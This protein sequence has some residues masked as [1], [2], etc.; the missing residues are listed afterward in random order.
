MKLHRIAILFGIVTVVGLGLASMGIRLTGA[1]TQAVPSSLSLL[2]Q[3]S[4][5][6]DDGEQGSIN[7]KEATSI[8]CTNMSTEN[9]QIEVRLYQWNGTDVFTGTVNMPPNRTF[10]FSTQNTTIYFDDVLLGGSPG[11]SAIFQ[12]SGQILTNR[13]EVNCSAQILDP[14]NYPPVFA[15]RLPLYDRNGNLLNHEPPQ[16]DLWVTKT[17]VPLKAFPHDTITYFIEYG[18]NGNALANQVVLTDVIPAELTNLTWVAT[19][20]LTPTTGTTYVWPIGD[21]LPDQTGWITVTGKPL[22]NIAD[23][24]LI[25]NAITIAGANPDQDYLNQHIEITIQV[26][27]PKLY[28]PITFR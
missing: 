22:P 1:E 27:Y 12:G 14:L 28:L 17:A 26:Y 19:P 8:H 21:L 7:R 18:N 2:Y 5:V 24:T 9:T 16:P 13:P 6:T 3:F 25:T 23:G 20:M 11:T 4:G 15:T 10:T